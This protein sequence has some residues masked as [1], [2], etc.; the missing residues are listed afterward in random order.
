MES[1]VLSRSLDLAISKRKHL[2]TTL[3]LFP[4][5]MLSLIKKLH[6]GFSVKNI[7]THNF[8]RTQARHHNL[9]QVVVDG[10]QAA[11][12]DKQ[13]HD[14]GMGYSLGLVGERLDSDL[15]QLLLQQRNSG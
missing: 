8:L 12:E 5:Y 1:H 4:P 11:V 10:R 2:V 7:N 6:K 15:L 13:E 9:Q 3:T 14:Q